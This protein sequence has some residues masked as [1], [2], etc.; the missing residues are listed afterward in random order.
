MISFKITDDVILVNT[1]FICLLLS[2]S[3]TVFPEKESSLDP[4]IIPE[5]ESVIVPVEVPLVRATEL[6]PAVA[7]DS[8]NELVAKDPERLSENV[9]VSEAAPSN[10]AFVTTGPTA[11]V[12]ASVDHSDAMVFPTLSDIVV[13]WNCTAG[14]AAVSKIELSIRLAV[15]PVPC[16]L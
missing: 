9:S 5:F 10:I 1:L 4:V 7:H 3:P 8:T 11:S 14:V 15:T 2:R 6:I 16:K 13:F 12:A